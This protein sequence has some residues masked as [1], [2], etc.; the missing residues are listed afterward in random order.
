MRMPEIEGCLGEF[1]DKVKEWCASLGPLIKETKENASML[2]LEA[3]AFQRKD[4]SSL[5]HN[6]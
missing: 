6:I 2:T 5:E 4:P 1:Q 3:E